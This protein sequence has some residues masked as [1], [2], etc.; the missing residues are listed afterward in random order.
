MELAE[1]IEGD[2]DDIPKLGISA[3]TERFGMENQP[4]RQQRALAA[5]YAS[6][7]FMDAQVGRVLEALD[8]LGLRENTIVVFT[9]DHG[10]HLGE[11]DFWQ[12]MSLHEE[13][14]R[15]PILIDAPGKAPA[16]TQGLAEQIDLFPTL[17]D[18]AGLPI[19]AHCQGVSLA[20]ALEDPELAHFWPRW[21]AQQ[22][23]SNR[24]QSTAA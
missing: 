13:S 17:A 9:A 22:D 7:S 20:P 4:W 6:V 19:P 18:L 1:R 11:H 23:G 21:H 16:V 5:Y 12:K 2:R 14:T 10:W 24:Y 3:T 8:R 15:I